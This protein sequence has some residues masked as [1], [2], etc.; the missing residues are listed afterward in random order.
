M[1]E[2]VESAYKSESH[3]EKTSNFWRQLSPEDSRKKES[4]FLSEDE[5][6]YY[7]DDV[8]FVQILEFSGLFLMKISKINFLGRFGG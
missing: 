2:I 4:A 5:E 6:D 3:L 8:R 7:D 1:I